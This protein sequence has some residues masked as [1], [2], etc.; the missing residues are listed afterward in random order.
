MSKLSRYNFETEVNG[1]VF[2]Y[3]AVRC[4]LLR[5]DDDNTAE[6]RRIQSGQA[7][8][9][10]HPL[11]RELMRG[12]MLVDDG[13]DESLLIRTESFRTRFGPTN[14]M[15][16]TIAP[17]LS[18]NLRCIYCFESAR[19]VHMSTEVEDAI[20]EYVSSKYPAGGKTFEI[21]WFGGE[22]LLRVDSMERL[23]RA[24][25]KLAGEKDFQ[26]RSHVVTNGVLFDTD[27][28]KLLKELNVAGAQ[29]TIDGGPGTHNARRP[30]ANGSGS[31]DIITANLKQVHPIIPCSVRVNL[32]QTNP[33]AGDEIMD[34]VEA[35]GMKNDLSFYFAPVVPSL[36]ACQSGAGGCHAPPEFAA[37][38][39][40]LYQKALARGFTNIGPY[41]RRRT[42]ACGAVL[43]EGYLVG[44]DGSLWK[45]WETA[46]LEDEIVG[47]ILR[48]NEFNPRLYEW[49]GW[50]A[51]D[52][53]DCRDCN[54]LPV[55]AGCC[56]W[57]WLLHKRGL[58][59]HLPCVS[60]RYTVK[61]LLDL[62]VHRIEA[63]RAA[64]PPAE[65]GD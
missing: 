20:I 25:M 31:F 65:A 24:F 50:D 36:E 55:A 6:Y 35:L 9:P 60:Y 13:L 8:D 5:L 12:G 14:S 41:P 22:P 26:Y 18:C 56:P 52:N 23:S 51:M 2:L 43:D 32:D 45:C 15:M 53:S 34:V 7:P 64:A 44:P 4:G 49:M 57:R 59:D 33:A 42:A 58:V 10:E 3:N 47:N 1:A 46:G 28:A 30:M 17:T 40:D 27:M 16:L 54:V 61:D 21:W 37:I 63:Q 48:P 19:P 38:E 29:I 39:I 11:T 62:H